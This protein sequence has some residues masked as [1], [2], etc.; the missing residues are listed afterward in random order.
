MTY[1]CH[2]EESRPAE[3]DGATKQS[4]PPDEIAAPFPKSETARNDI[5]RFSASQ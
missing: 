4:P 2:C 1:F 5:P 3:R